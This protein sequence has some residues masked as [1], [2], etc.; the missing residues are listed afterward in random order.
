M[1]VLFVFRDKKLLVWLVE[2]QEDKSKFSIYKLLRYTTDYMEEYPD[3]LVIPLVLF[4]GRKKWRKD[5]DKEL[6]TKFRGR[7]YLHFE[8]NFVKLFDFNAA[9]YYHVK[10]PVVKILLPKMNYRPEEKTRV[11][12][13]AYKGLYQLASKMLFDKYIDFID[14]YA[15]IEDNEREEIYK[16][17]TEHKETAMLAQYIREKGFTEGIQKGKLEGFQEGKLEGKLA[18]KF[19]EVSA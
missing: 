15:Q 2:F 17:I 18:R 1:P 4:T 11:I 5:V 10:N 16:K 8:Y 3:A 6:D 13:E 12:I 14:T 7:T 19:H 9:D